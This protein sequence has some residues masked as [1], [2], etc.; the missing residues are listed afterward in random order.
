MHRAWKGHLKGT[1]QEN[2]VE[3]YQMICLLEAEENPSIFHQLLQQFIQYWTHKEGTFVEFF[4]QH[5]AKRP[6]NTISLY[7]WHINTFFLIIETW[8]RCYRHFKHGD[9]DTNM[10]VER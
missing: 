9:T 8:A 10:Y 3:M 7:T 1:S 6:G 5:Y 2:Q 4:Q